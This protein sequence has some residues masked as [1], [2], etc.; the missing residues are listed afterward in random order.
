MFEVAGIENVDVVKSVTTHSR[1]YWSLI[2]LGDGWYHV[3]CTPRT[4]TG[5]NFFMVTDA[6][7][8]AYSSKHRNTHIFDT[9]LYPERATE[10][11][12]HYV[13][14]ATGTLTQ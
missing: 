2:N 3:D 8:E 7:L 14:Y 12:Q 10:S 13:N 5:D 4:G 11:V 6:E 9:T 1:H